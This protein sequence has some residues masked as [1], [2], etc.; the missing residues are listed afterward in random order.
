MGS[1]PV[2]GTSTCCGHGQEES[3]TCSLVFHAQNRAPF[4]LLILQVEEMFGLG[5]MGMRKD[6]GERVFVNW[7][8]AA[9]LASGQ[10][11]GLFLQVLHWFWATRSGWVGAE[12]QHSFTHQAQGGALFQICKGAVRALALARSPAYQHWTN[13]AP[14]PDAQLRLMSCLTLGA[15]PA[16]QS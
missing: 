8:S 13:A 10:G 12:V 3:I 4:K 7:H 6:H 2:L 14:L 1:I 16:L 5:N 11:C 9:A 15:D